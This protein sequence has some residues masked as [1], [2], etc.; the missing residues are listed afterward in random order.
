MLIAERTLDLLDETGPEILQKK[1]KVSR[2]E[3]RKM[4]AR[5]LFR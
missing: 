4:M 3:I 2:G 1:V 5:A